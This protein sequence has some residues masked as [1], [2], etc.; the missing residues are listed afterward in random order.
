[1]H[2]RGK[3][4]ELTVDHNGQSETLLCVPDYDFNWQHSDVSTDPLRTDTISNM[5]FKVTFDNSAENP[6]NPDPSQW[7]TW[8]DQTW[9]KMAVM[10][11]K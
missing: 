11:S 2:V 6:F 7:V 10:I 3:S 4:F 9:E 5:R 1:M 8:G